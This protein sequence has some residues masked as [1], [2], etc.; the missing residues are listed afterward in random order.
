MRI[1][2][3]SVNNA[4]RLAKDTLVKKD[5]Y[6][7]EGKSKIRDD[8]GFCPFENLFSLIN[9]QRLTAIYV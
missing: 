1:P 7:L 3:K 9:L 4:I 8:K 5:I 2:R 6:D